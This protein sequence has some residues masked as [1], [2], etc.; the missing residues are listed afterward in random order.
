MIS[1]SF[2]TGR[3]AFVFL[4]ALV[5]GFSDRAS[6]ALAQDNDQ[7]QAAAR[8]FN[9][10]AALQNNGLYERAA[11]R[12]TSFIQKYPND[13]RLDRVHYH[14]GICQLHAK[15]PQDAA[16]SFEMVLSKYPSFKK[17][18]GA[19]YNLAMAY[20]QLASASGRAEDHKKAAETFT[21]VATKYPQSPHVHKA[22]YLQG[23]S[24]YATGDVK[25]AVAV[26]K[27]LTTE[28]SDGPL[29]ADALYALGTAEQELELFADAAATFKSFLDNQAFSHHELAAEIRLR[30][31]MSLY[32]QEK[33]TDAE[34]QF[35]AVVSIEKFPHADF[36]LLRQGQC[37]L[38]TGKMSDAVALFVDLPKK[39]PDS[40]YKSA[41]QLAAGKCYYRTD[42]LNEAQAMLTPLAGKTEKE[43]AEAAY[44]LGRTLL[45]ME[46]AQEA[47]EVLQKAVGSFKEG[48][49][50]PY[51]EV[52]RIDALYELPDRR[53][54]TAAL[55]GE[56]VTQYPDHPVT[57]RAVYMAGLAALG[58]EDYQAACKHAEAFLANQKYADNEL[59]PAVV[60]VAAEAYLLA[61]DAG[62]GGGDAN[63]AQQLYR[64]L[65]SEYPDHS[66][67]ARSH[68]RVGWCLLREKKSD[69]SVAYLTGN[70]DKLKD[71]V[72]QA[73]AHLLIGQAHRAGSR[74]KEAVTALDAAL[75]AKPDWSRVDEALLASAQ[76]LRAMDQTDAAV[77]RL[78][79]LQSTCPKSSCRDQALY[80]LGEIAQEQKKPDDAIRWYDEVIKEHPGSEFAPSADYGLAA[81]YFSKQDYANT[82]I[83]L[84][85]LISGKGDAELVGRGR[86]LRGLTYQRQKQFEPAIEDL[87]DFLASGPSGETA[88]D[89][90]YALALCQI[91]LKQFDQASAALAALLKDKPD[92]A[93]ADKVYY[94]M[95]HALAQ[96]GKKAEAA[97]SFRALAEKIPDS[98]LA[99]ESWFRVGSY[100]EEN[101]DRTEDDA[102]RAA[103]L[104]RAGDAF[105]AGLGKAKVAEL[106]EKLQYKLGDMQFRQ[107]KYDLATKVLLD[108]INQHPNG[109]LI[110]PARF[111]AAESLY[112]QRQ[113]DQALPLFAGVAD[114]KVKNCHVQSLYRAGSCAAR[115]SNWPESA[116]R[117]KALIDQ[118][119]DF[120]LIN[121]A[122]YGLAFA[123]QKQNKPDEAVPLFE[124]VTKEANSETAAKARFMMG[125]I[126]FARQKYE[127]AIEHFLMVAVGYPYEKWQ[128]FA[129]FEAGR[130]FMELGQKEKAIAS[131]QIVVD[132]FADHGKAEDARRLIE[133][134]KKSH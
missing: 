124:Q 114:A 127:D 43:S 131:L 66:R 33:Y 63:K 37:R 32:D 110:G 100:H 68:L 121:E 19:L 73:E 96:Q 108:Q 25:G 14:L 109:E 6:R 31:G 11:Q 67:A 41:A 128:A 51:L 103:D 2:R 16:K 80:Q 30:L 28:Y 77:E 72:H 23:E 85:R 20:Q 22:L 52:A 97:V 12:W 10:V 65:V 120:E 24:L 39:F 107:K 83:A 56:F 82:L 116:N 101:S 53:N 105:T 76:S 117:Y 126:A 95:G 9:A 74:H 70:L 111:L 122:R 62:K 129:R 27:K 130:C 133:E 47:L 125:E 26:Y 1:E 8:D 48:E 99:A 21:A 46:K 79:R 13:K 34:P 3:I 94:E 15:K 91:G 69:E 29:L 17:S 78:S 90:R 60:F 5:T 54:E 102:Q 93:N 59:V 119:P 50:V 123:L 55:Y 61:L 132:K 35:A 44:W 98:P 88:L 7:D 92:Y 118:F 45:K 64:R 81:A 42:R 104:A 18:D 89:A 36:A 112:R 115:M 134:L 84:E 75:T 57:A 86:H 4:L 113:F 106:K 71:P 58:K 87:Q 38:Q 40:T 49:F